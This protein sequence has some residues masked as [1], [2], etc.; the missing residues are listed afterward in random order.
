M[1]LLGCFS[2]N[3]NVLLMFFNKGTEVNVADVKL[4]AS[5]SGMLYSCL[6]YIN[7]C[8]IL[9]VGIFL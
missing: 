1:G 6:C 2:C 3:Y 4:R 5:N 7:L 8:T 9:Y